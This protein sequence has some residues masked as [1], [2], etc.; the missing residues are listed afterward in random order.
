M[1]LAKPHHQVIFW[2]D[3]GEGEACPPAKSGSESI[4]KHTAR[5]TIFLF[6]KNP[7]KI[8]IRTK[9]NTSF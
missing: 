2:D 6:I 9:L 5:E 8:K 4:R 1:P 7:P 3:A